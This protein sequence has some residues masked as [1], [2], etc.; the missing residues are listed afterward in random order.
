LAGALHYERVLDAPAGPRWRSQGL[1]K[2]ATETLI[3]EPGIRTRAPHAPD[4]GGAAIGGAGFD[5]LMTACG[6]WL[7]G[8]LYLDGWAHIHR[9]AL[10]TFF[11]PWHAVLYSGYG[12]GAAA[13][14]LTFL[15]NRRRGAPRAHALPPGYRSSLVGAFI[16]FFGGVAD[17]LW[18]VTFGIEK[19]IE[20]LISPSHIALA[21][22]GGLMVT[23]PLRAGLARPAGAA[24]GWLAQ[25]PMVVSLTT[26][27]SLLTFFTEYV[28]P[29]G[30]TWIAEPPRG[31]GEVFLTAG[32]AGFL[33]QPVILMGLVLFVLRRRPLPLGSLTIILSINGALMTLIHDTFLRTG[34]YPL[35]GAAVLAGLVSD[36]LLR[37]LQPSADRPRAFRTFAFA[38]PAI[39]YLLYVVT[40]MR[41]AHVV[42]SV[43][44]WTGA[45]VLSGVVGWLLSYL[46]LPPDRVTAPRPTDI[47][48]IG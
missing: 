15:R 27:L 28:S 2:M 5:W 35:I 41:W 11:T 36:V 31:S 44:V 29:H 16:F 38:V 37:W 10:E 40:V 32:M 45:V 47:G 6:A 23:G 34:P 20:G 8:G 33:I 7:I 30:T 1:T 26:F 19:G 22:G 46:V 43:H 48:S 18:H 42:W 21:L 39:Q 14:V 9:P 3:S 13:L 24:Q 25:I 12:A 17:M 4:R